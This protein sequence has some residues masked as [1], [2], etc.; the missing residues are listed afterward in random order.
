MSIRLPLIASLLI[1][2]AMAAL[3]AWAWPLIPGAA[4]I[5]VH[6]DI[7]GVA[8][9]FADKKVALTLLPAI[10]LGLTVLLG[11]IPRFEPRRFNLA[12]SAK[13]YC[14]AWI[15]AIAVVAAAH[16][17]IVLGA[18]HVPVNGAQ[19]IVPAVAL[20]FIVMG[21][22]MGK[23]RANFFFG[24]R[25]PWTLSSDYSWEMT[26][27]LTGRLF[28]LAGAISLAAA[29]VLSPQLAFEIMI[30]SITAAALTGIL[31]SYIYWRRDPLRHSAD[32]IPE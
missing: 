14:V 22:Y 18:L 8:N 21:N 12:A 31:A 19:L 5:A 7:N 23:T 6:F 4:R 27:R 10:A 3:S 32:K 9:G 20:L 28:M 17:M 26:H 25:T 13:F 29:L 30:G 11:V 16:A 2:I 1:V 24:I 15:G